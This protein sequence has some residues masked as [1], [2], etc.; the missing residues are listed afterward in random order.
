MQQIHPNGSVPLKSDTQDCGNGGGSWHFLDSRARCILD[1]CQKSRSCRQPRSWVGARRTPPSPILTALTHS[2]SFQ[3]SWAF[4]GKRWR[5]HN[6][7]EGMEEAR[8]LP[9]WGRS[10][11]W[12]SLCWPS[13]MCRAVD[14]TTALEHGTRGERMESHGTHGNP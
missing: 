13:W 7:S 5:Y 11:Q 8:A 9:L 6:S 12:M 3:R 2:E 14:S 10:S 1:G 4:Y